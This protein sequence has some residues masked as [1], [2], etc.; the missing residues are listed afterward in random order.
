MPCILFSFILTST[1]CEDN[2]YG[3]SCST[4]CVARD[5]QDGHYTCDKDNGAKICK[6]GWSGPDC[7][8]G[9]LKKGRMYIVLENDL[10]LNENIK[11][12]GSIRFKNYCIKLADIAVVLTFILSL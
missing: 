7:L 11:T 4:E 12:Y 10:L 5:D 8:N 6:R 9:K 1:Q 2:W 3:S